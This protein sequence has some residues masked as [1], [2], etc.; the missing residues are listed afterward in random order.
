[1]R[2]LVDMNVSPRTVTFL[3]TQGYDAVRVS[4]IFPQNTP[5]IILLDYAR[6]H[7][8]IVL[9]NDLDFSDLIALNNH[10]SPSVLTLRLSNIE[11]D[12]IHAL[13]VRSLPALHAAMM[14]SHVIATLTERSLRIRS[15]PIE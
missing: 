1:V 4:S 15:L 5:D 6:E 12:V 3:K 11:P 13:L 7:E 10:A 14:N 2:F 8:Y 9:T